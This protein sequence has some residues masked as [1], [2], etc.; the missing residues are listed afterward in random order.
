MLPRRVAPPLNGALLCHT[1]RAFQKQLLTLSSTQPTNGTAILCHC[2]TS[3]Y[4]TSP[5]GCA[6][7][8][9]CLRL[10]QLAPLNATPLRW[11]ASVMRD[12]G[13]ITN[14]MDPQS[15]GLKGSDRRFTTRPRA[16][17]ID[18]HRAHSTLH[19]LPRSSLT[20]PLSGEG[21]AFAR[22]LEPLV[23]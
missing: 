15:S 22:T 11:T 8:F 13:H 3:G 16:I 9:S 18:I 10:S 1:A 23:P 7:H 6:Y 2:S 21:R 14:H 19:G 20:G 4:R 12:R 17:Y 5:C